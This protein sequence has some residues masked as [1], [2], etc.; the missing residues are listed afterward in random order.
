MLNRARLPMPSPTQLAILLDRWH[1]E[2]VHPTARRVSQ[3]AAQIN[4]L[5]Q[6]YTMIENNI[7]QLQSTQLLVIAAADNVPGLPQGTPQP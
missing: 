6:T 1:H 5:V 3:E 7:R 4:N 2:I